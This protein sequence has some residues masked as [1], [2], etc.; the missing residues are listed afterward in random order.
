MSKPSEGFRHYRHNVLGGTPST[1]GGVTMA[2]KADKHVQDLT[3]AD[4]VEVAFSFC[5]GADNFQRTVGRNVAGGRLKTRPATM[6]GDLFLKALHANT[7]ADM[8]MALGAEF[9]ER[10]AK[11]FGDC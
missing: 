5:S 9:H 11:T 8:A 1:K 2:F 10:V 7:P 6:P 4:T 3:A